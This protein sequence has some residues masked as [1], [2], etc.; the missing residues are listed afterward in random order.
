LQGARVRLFC[1]PYAGAGASIYRPWVSELAE[2][3]DV[4]AVQPPGRET[5]FKEPPVADLDTLVELVTEAI[6]P[7]LDVPAVF[8]GHS[9]GAAVAF[10]VA[11]RLDAPLRGCPVTLVV[12]G[13]RAPHL[14][15]DREDRLH[16]L[17]D[18]RFI[19]EIQKRFGGIP[20]QVLEHPDLL[21]LLLP[22]LRADIA[23]LE[24]HV[25]RCHEPV[26]FPIVA[27]GGMDDPRV[28]TADLAAW[29]Q[30]TRGTFSMRLFRG[31][32]FY[33]QSE[34]GPLLEALSAILEGATAP[35]LKGA[36]T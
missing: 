5:R 3:V 18:P 14:P 26:A 29:K 30:A 20:Q 22:T 27:F 33:L 19:A 23:A 1:F 4:W 31:G 11:R 32:H 2:H 21:A 12:S 7:H 15:D 36:G 28:S 35:L 16:T 24:R 6:R 13:R 10:E 8:F 17:D 25:L 34:R 9:M